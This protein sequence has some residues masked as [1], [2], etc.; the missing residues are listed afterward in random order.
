MTHEPLEYAK[1][2]MPV[3]IE[4]NR[5]GWL[6]AFGVVSILIGCLAGCGVASMI[7]MVFMFARMGGGAAALGMP[8]DAMMIFGLVTAVYLSA[9]VLF[10]WV[11]ID[12]I[13][14]R[15]WVRPV[16]IAVGWLTIVASLFMLAAL[17]VAWAQAPPGAP[18]APVATSSATSTSTSGVD[19]NGNTTTTTVTTDGTG[20]TTTTT[21]T[22]TPAGATISSSTSM[23]SGAMAAGGADRTYLLINVA[24]F[25]VI[26][27]AVP[28]AY[29]GFFATPA[30]RRTLEAYSPEP[31]WS[32]RPPVPV[33]VACV[34]LLLGGLCTI[35][36]AFVAAAPFFGTYLTG[37]AAIALTLAAAVTMAAAAALMFVGRSAGWWAG[38]AVIG[39]GFASTTISL[40]TKGPAEFYR[41][42]GMSNHEV[43]DALGSPATGGVMPVVFTV[44]AGVISL[45]YLFWL[46]KWFWARRTA[47]WYGAGRG[48]P[49]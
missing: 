9:A 47:E 21:T 43:A 44:A 45:G 40:I 25:L 5:R 2:L 31:A 14:C 11:G 16:V 26:G 34:A 20:T 28:A 36:T 38:V 37:A 33:F 6:I 1:P 46:G 39:L 49:V 3:P 24:I 27:V 19:A 42:G 32:E 41:R 23:T 29:V 18:G 4:D 30:V 13:R 7:A 8:P 12:S 17:V 10:V 48:T 22:T 35:P 15:R